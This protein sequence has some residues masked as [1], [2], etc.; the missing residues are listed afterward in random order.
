MFKRWRKLEKDFKNKDNS[1]DIS[2]IPDICDNIKYDLLHNPQFMD[3]KRRKLFEIAYLMS[4]IIVPLEYGVNNEEKLTIGFKIIHH[5]LNKIYHD[6]LWW[7]SPEWVNL[8]Q[9]FED[10]YQSWEEKGLDYSRLEGLVKSHWRHIRTRL[11]FTSASHMYTL[12]NTLKLG[13]NSFLVDQTNEE[14]RDALEN[15]T[16]LD[17]MSGIVFRLYENLGLDQDDPK[18]FRLE[19]MVHRGAVVENFD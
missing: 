11:Y 9:D 17:Y 1:Y 6:L 16:T 19:L 13:V 8:H 5:L 7:M 10:E 14:D 15:I 18:R 3:E 4:Q 12:L 2:K